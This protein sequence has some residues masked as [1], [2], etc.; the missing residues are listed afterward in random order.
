MSKKII[1]VTGAGGYIGSVLVPKL[2]SKGYAVKAIDRFFFG[3]DKLS[4]HDDLQIIREDVRHLSNSHFSGVNSVIDLVAISNDPA[5][6]YFDKATWE[7]NHKSRVNTARLAQAAGVERYL[8][9]SSCSIYGFQDNVVDENSTINPLTTYAKANRKAEEEVLPLYSPDFTVTVIRQATVFGWSPRL[10]LDLAVNGM[11]YGAFKNKKL[12][13]MRDGEQFRPM[14]HVEDTTDAMIA[15]IE[16][17]KESVNGEIFNVGGNPMNYKIKTLAETA[18]KCASEFLEEDIPIEWYGDPDHRSYQ[19]NFD[20][21]NNHIGWK[22][23]L[24]AEDGIKYLLE[25]LSKHESELNIDQC[26]TLKWYQSLEHWDGILSGM[27]QHGGLINI[28]ARA[29]E[30][31]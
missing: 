2:L 22:A 17:E 7:I 11:T 10:R 21:I 9:P 31:V 29:L 20:K 26:L 25:W 5:G 14:V 24:T 23:K 8:L 13:V 12:P 1:V 19:V 3:V 28:Q 18:V 27:K 4:A 16:A 6:D 15:I 30:G